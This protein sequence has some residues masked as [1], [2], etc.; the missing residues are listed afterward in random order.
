MVSGLSSLVEFL[1]IVC[2]FFDELPLLTLLLRWFDEYTFPKGKCHL[3][4]DKMTVFY[5]V[6]THRI[7][8]VLLII[9]WIT[10][11]CAK[12]R[13]PSLINRKLCWEEL[14]ES[15]KTHS[16]YLWKKWI[17][18][19]LLGWG[20]RKNKPSRSQRC[21]SR[22]HWLWKHWKQAGKYLLTSG[23]KS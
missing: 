1:I 9:A 4:K 14:E 21:I 15:E 3:N 8:A 23:S 6:Q 10:E 13:T 18:N 16:I 7:V 12:Q 22:Q 2:K 11:L 19:R 17:C 20:E 5:P